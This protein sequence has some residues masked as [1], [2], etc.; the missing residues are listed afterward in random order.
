[1]LMKF[2]E[3]NQRKLTLLSFLIYELFRADKKK[4]ISNISMHIIY[5]LKK[6]FTQFNSCEIHCGYVD[7]E[8][9]YG[10]SINEN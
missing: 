8:R 4:T 3:S 7:Y 1:M 9:A 6:D 10:Y 5:P 2:F